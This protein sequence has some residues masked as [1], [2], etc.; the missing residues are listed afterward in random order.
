MA[1]NLRVA[2]VTGASRG[3]GRAC[4]VALGR[5]G[6]RV[7]V[8]YHH[9]ADLA[10]ET[11]EAITKAGGEAITVGADVQNAEEA[12]RLVKTVLDQW[13]RLDVLVNNAGV[14]RDDLVLRLKEQDWDAVINVNLK[15]VFLV[16]KAALRPMVRA[17]YGR[18]IN[19]ASVAGLAGNPGQANY[20]A[21]K[22]GV[23]GF[24]KSLALEVASRNIT[25]NAVAPGLVETDMTAS[26]PEAARARLLANIPLGRSARPEE[27]AYVV[28]FLASEQASYIT[29][30]TINVSG[31]LVIS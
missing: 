23:I 9:A 26:M 12:E 31:G 16:T 6:F 15:G 25:V 18:I 24:T 4:A 17:R 28:S 1:M 7:V 27:V 11:A 5:D 20:A 22:A 29:G 8:H 10:L 13:G 2:L 30:Q 14:T 19:I 3:I 21:S